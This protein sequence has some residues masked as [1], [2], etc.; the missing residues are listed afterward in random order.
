MTYNKLCVCICGHTYTHTYTHAHTRTHTH[1][2]T[3]TYTHTYT[4]IHTHTYKHKLISS[5]RSMLIYDSHTGGDTPF[6]KSILGGYNILFAYY[7]V[8]P[9]SKILFVGPSV[10]RMKECSKVDLCLLI[11]ILDLITH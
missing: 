9:T 5:S 6:R 2:H 10:L 1:I 11:G 7:V 8:W 3:H 4:H